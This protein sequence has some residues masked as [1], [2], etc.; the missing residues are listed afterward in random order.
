MS[1]CVYRIQSLRDGRG[2]FRPGFSV[3][4]SDREGEARLPTFLEEFPTLEFKRGMHHGTGVRKLEDINRWFTDTEQARLCLLGYRVVS[5]EVDEVLA[6]SKNQVVF[7][8]KLPLTHGGLVVP[9][10]RQVGI[11]P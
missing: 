2:P 5:M 7:A 10:P 4:W 6:E 11:T 8:R 1:E 9:W 3:R